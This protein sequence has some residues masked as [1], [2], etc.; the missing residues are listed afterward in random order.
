MQLLRD[1]ERHI[2]ENRTKP[3]CRYRL[4]PLNI[5]NEYI[6][7]LLGP[8]WDHRVGHEFL[9]LPVSGALLWLL[10]CIY[11]WLNTTY[12][13]QDALCLHVSNLCTVSWGLP[14]SSPDSLYRSS[15][16]SRHGTDTA[17]WTAQQRVEIQKC[18]SFFRICQCEWMWMWTYF[19]LYSIM[20]CAYLNVFRF[21][22]SLPHY[23][24]R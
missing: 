18:D 2:N 20:R 3:R 6:L 21:K 22:R 14:S 24:R 10:A 1:S 15:L 12:K 16:Q 17:Q 5:V 13:S 8:P 9:S 4:F 23:T 7:S 11:C 19:H